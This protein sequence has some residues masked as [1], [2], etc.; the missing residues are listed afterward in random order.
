MANCN[1]SRSRSREYDAQHVMR[2][3]SDRHIA[4]HIER[5]RKNE[6]QV[7][8]GVLADQVD[9]ARRTIITRVW[10]CA[11]LLA[12][13]RYDFARYESQ[14]RHSSENQHRRCRTR[15]S[16]L[17]AASSGARTSGCTRP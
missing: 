13:L 16:H 17:Y 14:S 15:D 6:T 3:R 4:R 11:E 7:V 1:S 9:P 12:K 10:I 5:N 2:R 8:I